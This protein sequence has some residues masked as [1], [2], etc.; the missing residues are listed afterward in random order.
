MTARATDLRPSVATLW[1]TDDDSDDADDEEEEEEEEEAEAAP[2][3]RPRRRCSESASAS[4][5]GGQ[6]GSLRRWPRPHGHPHA[7]QSQYK[8]TTTK[9]NHIICILIGCSGSMP[10]PTPPRRHRSSLAGRR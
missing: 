1:P 7:C 5:G 4:D 2:F 8:K 9:D 10:M 3:L 6:S